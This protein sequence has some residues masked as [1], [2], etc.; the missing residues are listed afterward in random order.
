MDYE[1]NIIATS[2]STPV[3]ERL[4][5]CLLVPSGTLQSCVML[6]HRPT[7]WIGLLFVLVSL[8]LGRQLCCAIVQSGNSICAR[9]NRAIGYVLAGAMEFR[10]SSTSTASS[11]MRIRPFGC[12]PRGPF[13]KPLF[14]SCL[15]TISPLWC[16][17]FMSFR[18]ATLEWPSRLT[19]CDRKRVNDRG[20][21]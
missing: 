14:Y 10:I 2:A 16:H 19:I 5:S 3:Q 20:K 1:Q 18:V 12:W 21:K 15:S 11:S 13:G 7:L 4:A 8:L 6:P 17:Y 9:D